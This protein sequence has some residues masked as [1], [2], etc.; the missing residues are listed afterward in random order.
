MSLRRRVEFA[1]YRSS[2]NPTDPV[3]FILRSQ[4][5]AGAVSCYI[6]QRIVCECFFQFFRLSD[7]SSLLRR[8]QGRPLNIRL[9]LP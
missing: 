6:T 8:A 4:M 5:L 1:I 7:C 9:K 2:E 3:C